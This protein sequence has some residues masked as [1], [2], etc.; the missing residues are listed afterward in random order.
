MCMLRPNDCSTVPARAVAARNALRQADPRFAIDAVSQPTGLHYSWTQ[1]VTDS[2]RV[3][4]VHLNLFPGH[5]CGSPANPGREG[6]PGTGFPCSDSW[7]WPEDSLGFVSQ[8]R[9]RVV[10]CA[11]QPHSSLPHD[12]HVLNPRRNPVQLQTDL[13]AHATAPGTL[14]V[15]IMHYGLDGWSQTWFSGSRAG[16][17][18]SH[19]EQG[20]FARA[21][22]RAHLA[23]VALSLSLSLSLSLYLPRSYL[24]LRLV[25][26]PRRR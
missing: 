3:H 9:L 8:F 22:A 26:P 6:P 24:S 20:A 17:L 25:D 12:H 19:R 4:F 7:T 14:V 5:Q 2:C 10:P 15:T 13:A 21:R 18:H 1:N 11:P 23:M 16:K